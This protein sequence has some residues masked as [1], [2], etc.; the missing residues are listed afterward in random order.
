LGIILPR[1]VVKKGRLRPK[2]EAIVEVIK[3][4]I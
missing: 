1:E 2:G 3:N 4:Q